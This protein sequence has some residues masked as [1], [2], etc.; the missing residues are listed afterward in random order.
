[1][2][3][4]RLWFVLPLFLAL[5]RP[6]TATGLP[7]PLPTPANTTEGQA[8]TLTAGCVVS[9]SAGLDPE[10]VRE[11]AWLTALYR[12]AAQIQPQDPG[13]QLRV[14]AAHPQYDLLGWL[15]SSQIVGEPS[16]R[17]VVRVTLQ[18]PPL[19]A[20]DSRPPLPGRALQADVDGDGRD[21][22][23]RLAPDSRVYVHRG[24]ELLT[25]SPGLGHLAARALPGPQGMCELVRLSR[26]TEVLAAEPAGP[27]QARLL[28]R[29]RHSEVL[30]LRLAG[31]T[32]EDREVLLRLV[33]PGQAP[34]IQISEPDLRRPLTQSRVALRGSVR[35]PAGLREV[36]LSLNGRP[37]W[38]SPQG[39]SSQDLRLDLVLDLRPGENCAVLK[40]TDRNGLAVERRLDLRSPVPALPGQGAALVVDPGVPGAAAEAVGPALREAGL[41]VHQKKPSEVSPQ[42]LETLA[43]EGRSGVPLV[44]YLSGRIDPEGHWI[45]EGAP[46]FDLAGA[47]QTLSGCRVLVVL[48]PGPGTDL[49]DGRA[50]WL[51]VSSLLDRLSGPGRLLLVSGGGRQGGPG[52]LIRVLTEAWKVAG[53]PLE[54]ALRAYTSAMAD[55]GA[56][57][58][59]PLPL[60]RQD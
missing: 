46:D 48:D 19:E 15:L 28:L 23:I 58:L 16:S 14:D 26:P 53:D 51:A 4:P 44:L 38:S 52:S 47:L 35:A 17:G 33:P 50:F 3:I 59:V 29:F 45:L 39:L 49:T 12:L 13:A 27:G 11:A 42:V 55:I 41:T 6:S 5:L 31:R 43:Q 24:E 22:R 57:T 56:G 30:G 25:V 7:D 1:M 10:D 20:L 34:T 36:Q 21:E 54:A 60:L 32:E 18:S 8:S 9:P 40:A 37:W 2:R